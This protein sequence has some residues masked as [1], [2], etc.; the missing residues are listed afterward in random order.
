MS[1]PAPPDNGSPV[2]PSGGGGDSFDNF[3]NG[4]GQ[5]IAG[6]L[7]SVGGAI[8]KATLG[9]LGIKAGL[10]DQ[11]LNTLFYSFCAVAGISAMVIGLNLIV[12]EVP[13]ASG[14]G[15][16]LGS[17]GGGAVGVGGSAARGVGSVGGRAVNLGKGLGE[18][19]ASVAAPEAAI[20][21][22]VVAD[23]GPTGSHAKRPNT[24]Q[25]TVKSLSNKAIRDEVK[26]QRYGAHSAFRKSDEPK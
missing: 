5:T 25:K 14:V 12:K 21:A 23:I 18:R 15:S 20:P 13:G 6:Q 9:A 16:V 1:S 26:T 19:L 2:S 11:I 8:G 3:I 22:K 17:I 10:I 24:G 7:P 4:L